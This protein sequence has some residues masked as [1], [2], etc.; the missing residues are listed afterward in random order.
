MLLHPDEVDGRDSRRLRPFRRDGLG[1][2]GVAVLFRSGLRCPL[3]SSTPHAE[4]VAPTYTKIHQVL[5]NPIYAGVYVYGRT[6][7]PLPRRERTG[8]QTNET[9]RAPSGRSSS[10]IITRALIDWEPS[11]RPARI[12]QNIRPRP[13]Q[14]GGAVR[15]GGALCRASDADIVADGCVALHRPRSAPWLPLR[16]PE[17]RQRPWRILPERRRLQIDAAIAAAFLAAF[18]PA[19]LRRQSRPPSKSEPT[20]S[21]LRSSSAMSSARVTERNAPSDATARSIPRPPRRPRA[22]SDREKACTTTKRG[23]E[24]ARRHTPGRGR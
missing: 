5:T 7:Q 4:W 13:H 12:A 22:P 21:P 15:E 20:T 11:S 6:Q 10:A 17:H 23:A 1:A 2:A 3:Q 24:L 19:A 14:A 18:A 9:A 8:P 16:R